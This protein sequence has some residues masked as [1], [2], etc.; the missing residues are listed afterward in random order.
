M[1]V[2]S[3]LHLVSSILV[4]TIIATKKDNGSA[5]PDVSYFDSYHKFEEHLQF[6]KDLSS[7]FS[8]NSEVFVAGDSLEG[9]PLQ[10]I[11]IW[12]SGGAGSKPAIVWH[13]NVHA[14]EWITSVVCPSGIHGNW[15]C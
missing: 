15:G 3:K 7:A 5:L 10:G 8:D 9:R 2:R 12:G 6:L 4:L 13:G 14:R 11:H 1:F